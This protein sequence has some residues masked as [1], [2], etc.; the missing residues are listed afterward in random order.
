VPRVLYFHENQLAYPARAGRVVERDLH[1]GVT[2]MTSALA[3]TCCVF[4][5]EY[6]RDSF[7]DEAR[8]LL[9]R[10]PGPLPPGWGEALAE[11]SEVLPVPLALPE[12][13][14][15]PE[16]PREDPERRLGPIVLWNHRWEHDKAPERFFGALV[17]V[18]EAG[19]PFRL[20][21]CGRRYRRAPAVFE[22]ARERLADHVVH[23]G[24]LPDREAYAAWL[25]RSHLAVSTA[26][27]EFF[28]VAML[29]ATHAGAR[30]LVPNRLAYPEVFPE[31]YRYDEGPGD[32]LVAR[33]VEL[34]AGWARGE[35]DL[36][37]DRRHLSRRFE[38]SS[39]LPRYGAL[40]EALA[41]GQEGAGAGAGVARGVGEGQGTG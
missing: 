27:H 6:N 36:R 26:V 24:A 38:A 40:L 12:E 4:N 31:A 9:A 21:V 32:G 23:W 1:Y 19:V 25:R 17:R 13:T 22:E 18:S 8:R 11:R 41:G 15:A 14:P 28:G 20:A 5:S 16:V 30:P 37:K 33:L 35:L 39:V 34:C 10:M 29:E 2:Q 7:L 3:A